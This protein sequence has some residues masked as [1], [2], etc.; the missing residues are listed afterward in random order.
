MLHPLRE[1]DSQWGLWQKPAT[2][3]KNE[4]AL[5]T[6]ASVIN[7]TLS[8]MFV[9]GC[10]CSIGLKYNRWRE[11]EAL[12]HKFLSNF[13]EWKYFFKHRG[14]AL[15]QKDLRSSKAKLPVWGLV[16]RLFWLPLMQLSLLVYTSFLLLLSVFGISKASHQHC[17]IYQRFLL[18]PFAELSRLSN[19]TSLWF[20]IWKSH[21]ILPLSSSMSLAISSILT[22]GFQTHTLHLHS[23]PFPV[24]STC[25]HLTA[26]CYI[27]SV[28]RGQWHPGS[29][30]MWE[31]LAFNIFQSCLFYPLVQLLNISRSFS[32]L[33]SSYTFPLRSWWSLL[34]VDVEHS[35][36]H[37]CT[38]QWHHLPSWSYSPEWL[39]YGPVVGAFLLFCYFL[40]PSGPWSCLES[41]FCWSRLQWHLTAASMLCRGRLQACHVTLGCMSWP[42][43]SA[44]LPSLCTFN[45]G[46]KMFIQ[47]T[48]KSSTVGVPHTLVAF[49]NEP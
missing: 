33:E 11:R 9:F 49:R 36:L 16:S 43:L 27:L 7:M 46:H 30:F 14:R 17:C 12:G 37:V 38:R 26:W 8:S 45:K 35:S 18:L 22:M 21:R 28:Y 1:D 29:R 5:I 34:Q 15:L 2:E 6:G 39:F 3:L 24:Y 47:T 10:P 31:T 25:L 41:C 48:T 4:S 13:A 42:P 40:L 19:I 20:C 23:I 32:H 44:L